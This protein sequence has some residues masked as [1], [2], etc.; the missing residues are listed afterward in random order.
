[1]VLKIY[2]LLGKEVKTLIDG[3]QKAGKH[4]VVWDAT[5]DSGQVIPPGIYYCNAKVNNDIHCRKIL[6]I[7]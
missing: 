2:D 5:D 4:S 3:V 7:E 1:M 6:Y